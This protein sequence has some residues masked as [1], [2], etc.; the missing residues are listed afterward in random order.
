MISYSVELISL[1]PPTR[2]RRLRPRLPPDDREVLWPELLDPVPA[3]TGVHHARGGVDAGHQ[4][5]GGTDR[6][7]DDGGEGDAG[8]TARGGAAALHPA[9]EPEPFRGVV[10]GKEGEVLRGRPGS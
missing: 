2:V 5:R 6:L 4:R 1:L 10:Q 3:R 7:S 8:A 9:L